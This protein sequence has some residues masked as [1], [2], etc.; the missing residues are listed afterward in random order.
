MAK[1]STPR[2]PEVLV[3]PDEVKAFAQ[4]VA[5]VAIRDEI[6]E[7]VVSPAKDKATAGNAESPQILSLDVADL[8]LEPLQWK[9]WDEVW[10]PE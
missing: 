9:E 6:A 7:A 4:F 10:D 5:R 3:P 2:E 8:Q 1:Q